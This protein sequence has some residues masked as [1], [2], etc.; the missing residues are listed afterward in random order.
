MEKEKISLGDS[1]EG[2]L[3]EQL[4]QFNITETWLWLMAKFSYDH[5][6]NLA[7]R[8]I[9]II[10]LSISLKRHCEYIASRVIALDRWPAWVAVGVPTAL[11]MTLEPGF[12]RHVA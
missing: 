2:L 7:I 1:S 5:S 10:Y 9:S 4:V 11:G 8:T 3:A 12:I 6:Q